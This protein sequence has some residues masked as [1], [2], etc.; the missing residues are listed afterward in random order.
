MS[1]AFHKSSL[2]LN[3]LT[4]MYAVAYLGYGRHGTCHGRHFDGGAKLLGKNLNFYLQCLEPIF[5]VPYIHKLLTASTQRPCLMHLVGRV[6]PAPPNI[7]TKLWYCD[8]TR[9]LDLVIQQERSV[10]HLRDLVLLTL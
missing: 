9:R 3:Y 4:L 6:A 8:T 10:T 5:C 2:F 1:D 7:M